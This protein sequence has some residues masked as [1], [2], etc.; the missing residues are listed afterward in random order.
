MTKFILLTTTL[1][2]TATGFSQ[3][4]LEYI[5]DSSEL[6]VSIDLKRV[7]QHFPMN[8]TANYQFIAS[9]FENYLNTGGTSVNVSELGINLEGKPT[10][11]AG[12][13]AQYSFQGMIVQLS[14]PNTFIT[15]T[16]S[17]NIIRKELLENSIYIEN[18]TLYLIHKNTYIS[19]TIQATE[20]LAYRITDSIFDANEWKKPFRWEAF[21]G[22]MD[23]ESIAVEEEIIEDW[24]VEEIIE[25]VE[26][27]L[28]E[29]ANDSTDVK[30]FLELFAELN[31]TDDDR[32]Y[33]Y[34]DSIVEVLSEQFARTFAQHIQQ[35]SP[36]LFR[37]SDA[38]KTSLKR[39]ADVT[40]YINPKGM[41]NQ[42]EFPYVRQNPFLMGYDQFLSRTWQTGYLNF[43]TTGIDMEWVNHL[44]KDMI[45]VMKSMQKSKFDK[46]LLN[47]IPNY[48][49]AFMT[50]NINTLEAYRT[51]KS[52]Y[53]P[54][55]ENSDDAREML[56]GA[57]WALVDEI[58]DDQALFDLYMSK[59]FISFNGVRDM[60]VERI[61]YDYDEESF[62]YTEI[63]EKTTDKVPAITFGMS[64]GRSHLATKFLNAFAKSQEA[65]IQEGHYYKMKRGP[66]PGVPFYIMVQGDIIIMTNEVEVVRN[67][68][69]G[70]GKL[71]IS[72]KLAKTA[73]NAKMIYM[74]ADMRNIPSAISDLIVNASDRHFVQALI[75]RTGELEVN[76]GQ[77]QKESYSFRGT[78]S[79]HGNYKNGAYYLMDVLNL[80]MSYDDVYHGE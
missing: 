55:L 47:Y 18:G 42:G 27:E 31:D 13:N 17:D 54:K 41:Y 30:S 76:L 14:K 45:G 66:V 35:E 58:I 78:Y 23:W 24:E 22:N 7:S 73:G 52:T 44:D 2:W 69:G 68:K 33:A 46:K 56:V 50:M 51:F 15:K 48:S 11:F 49:A 75:D 39:A 64:T 8:E 72:G 3:H 19:A 25:E 9:V 34:K 71:A 37:N 4:E 28:A 1:I 63:I 59:A 6:V 38:F 65:I 57:V 5:P 36:G 67:H 53:M 12:S 77:L 20:E 74:K 32:Y 21:W 16:I 60:E 40:I 79:F 43:T 29:E 61:T 62:E 10:Y 70:Y 26:A 80:M